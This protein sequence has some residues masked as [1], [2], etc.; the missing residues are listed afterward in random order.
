MRIAR[1]A[2]FR[3]LLFCF[4]AA[5][6]VA[7]IGTK[8][9]GAKRALECESKSEVAYSLALPLTRIRAI[10]RLNDKIKSR[11]IARTARARNLKLIHTHGISAGLAALKARDLEPGIRV[12][13]DM[14]GIGPEEHMLAKGLDV[15]D[16]R[17]EWLADN[18]S[19]LIEAA[20]GV[21]FVSKSM[22]SHYFEKYAIHS[23]HAVTIP[24]CA[25]DNPPDPKARERIRGELGLNGRH[26]V[27]YL[28]SSEGYQLP[29]IMCSIF[30]AISREAEGAFFLVISHDAEVFEKSLRA[31]GV[32]AQDYH[33]VGVR[34]AEVSNYLAAMDVGLLLRDDSPVN[35]VAFPTKFAEYCAAGVPV[36][37]TPFVGDVTEIVQSED[38]GLVVDPHDE[39]AAVSIARF[40]G[41][42]G[43]NRESVGL[44]CEKFVSE[45]LT[46]KGFGPTLVSL[47]H[48][49]KNV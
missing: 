38:L 46:W 17:A 15:V 32:E 9:A 10:S 34:H 2:G 6:K 8:L 4:V 49:L 33:I 48:E 35:R 36:V 13:A 31:N 22:G 11:V 23:E 40:I 45:N 27:G 3:T 29:E 19:A 44:R 12:I 28:G 25:E 14:H 24:C 7:T 26:V 39:G 43:R 41:E 5:H 30:K 1:E 42:V 21:V 18:E 37:S 16:S 47:Y 20:D